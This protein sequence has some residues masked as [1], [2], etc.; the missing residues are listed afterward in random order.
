MEF[1]CL[2]F[3][4]YLLNAYPSS[5]LAYPTWMQYD[6]DVPSGRSG[7]NSQDLTLNMITKGI[8]K[9][10]LIQSA[11]MIGD[12]CAASQRLSVSFNRRIHG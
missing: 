12:N 4:V 3:K 5:P 7:F 10:S 9:S 11:A 1:V 2:I 6:F 8:E